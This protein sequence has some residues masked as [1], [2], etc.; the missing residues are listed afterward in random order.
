MVHRWITL[1]LD[2]DSMDMKSTMFLPNSTIATGQ[3]CPD[4]RR[5]P[6]LVSFL[7][8]VC[9]FLITVTKKNTSQGSLFA[10]MWAMLILAI[11]LPIVIVVSAPV[12]LDLLAGPCYLDSKSHSLLMNCGQEIFSLEEFFGAAYAC[13]GHFWRILAKAANF[14]SPGFAQTFINGLT[15]VGENSGASA[16]MPGL[17]GAFSK[18][19]VNDPAESLQGVQDLISGGSRFGPM[20]LFMKTAMNPI[21]GT[22]WMW[23]MA[24]R[25]IVQSIQAS[26]E[27]RSVA[28]IFWNAVYEGRVDYKELVS[29]RMF[30]TCGGLA[31]M[32]GYFTPMG[33]MILHYCFAGVKST[34]ATLDLVSIFMVDL[35]VIVCICK[36]T[37]GENPASWIVKHCEAPDGLKPRL[38]R[39][40]DSPDACAAMMATTNAN[41]TG[42][43]DDVFGELFTGT[44]SVGSVLD[45]FVA[46][47]DPEKAGQC[48]NF[49]TN[50]YVVTLIPE[51]A[52]YWR[53]CGSTD[54]CRLRCQQQIEAFE[55]VR[56]GNSVRSTTTTQTVQS[57]LFPSLNADAYNPFTAGGVVALTELSSCAAL[58][59]DAEDRCFLMAGFVG[60]GKLSIAQYCVPSALARGVSKAGS[61][62]TLGISGLSTEIQFVKA[63]IPGG[64]R[65]VFCV[66]GMQDQLIQAC[67]RLACAE[68]KPSDVDLQALGFHK[69]QSL[70]DVV[71]LQVRARKGDLVSY[72][73]RFN[74][75]W[76]LNACAAN[77]NIW[78]QSM[79]HLVTSFVTDQALLMPYDEVPLQICDIDR[80][81][82]RLDNCQSYEGFERQNVPVK[83]KGLQSR[84]SQSTSVE[85]SVFVASNDPSH[86]LTILFLDVSG[87]QVS[88]SISNSMSV[89]LQYTLQQKCS[90]DSCIGCTQLSVQRLCYA[91][92]RCQVARCIGSQVN[93]IRPLCAVG[94][95]VEATM[96]AMLAI[97]QGVWTML[98]SALSGILDISGGIE[99]PKT[100]KWPDQVFYGLICSLKDTIASQV[101]ILTSMVNGIMQASMPIVDQDMGETTDN[102]FLATFT[103]TMTAVTKFLFQLCLGPLYVAIAAQKVVV[104]QANSLVAVVSGNSV[105]IGDPSIQTASTAA[106]GACMTQF[107]TENAQG[108]NSGVDNGRAFTSASMDIITQL[109]GLA[110]ALPLDAIR[111]PID[112]V[113]TYALGVVRGLQ[114]I[115]QTTD[116]RK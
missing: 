43:F 77:T 90:L 58:C 37:A 13:N 32:A 87:T 111:H 62:E 115:L 1:F 21:A 114:D 108:T 64:W 71:V 100:I 69:I 116:Q 44:S 66:V 102:H 55:K 105:S 28:G 14:L 51:P 10:E 52:D 88:S 24:S 91:A 8:Q 9:L 39:V 63:S 34:T 92:Q 26:R 103:L 4:Q 46:A 42:V 45:S 72:C 22:H 94:G 11:R 107:S 98:S 99:P 33:N 85:Y 97:V 40:M 18:I 48:D 109:G 7:V 79:Y 59:L 67:S 12:L 41:L 104:C 23:R 57:L 89:R 82:I 20:S 2:P 81:N 110:T 50:P 31:L 25:I 35:P 70:G 84:V 112:V 17:I 80:Q 73:L 74:S 75:K 47:V 113:F 54:F 15:S 27:Q 16:F 86:W 30:N 6:Q 106:A 29:T 76:K 3:L 36:Q 56:P 95:S 96:F 61:W 93:Q 78:D 60:A 101:S 53:V 68:F 5:M 83:T 38:R 65:D 49:E 19:S